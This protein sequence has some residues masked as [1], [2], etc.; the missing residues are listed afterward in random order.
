MEESGETMEEERCGCLCLSAALGE[1]VCG[2]E[3]AL[4]NSDTGSYVSPFIRGVRIEILFQRVVLKAITDAVVC[5]MV[6]ARCTLTLR[7]LLPILLSFISPFLRLSFCSFVL[8]W[9]GGKS[10]RD[11]L[12]HTHSHTHTSITAEVLLSHNMHRP[13]L[14][15]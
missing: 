9:A 14:P 1:R 11:S 15:V 4:I 2:E 6:V 13:S 7:L 3:Q 10:L 8:V 5:K 12:T